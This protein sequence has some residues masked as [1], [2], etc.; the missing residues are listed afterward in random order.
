MNKKGRI[1][2]CFIQLLVILLVAFFSTGN[3]AALSDDEKKAI[4]IEAT[5]IILPLVE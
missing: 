1:G 5:K 2:F 4:G 3:V